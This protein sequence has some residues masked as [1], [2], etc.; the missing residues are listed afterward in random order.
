MIKFTI[1]G[2]PCAKGRARAA[3]RGASIIHYTPEK[4]ANY[5]AIVQLAARQAFAAVK[6][7]PFEGPVTL[8]VFA[9]M[10]IAKSWA[11]KRQE[12]ARNGRDRPTKKPDLSNIV[13]AIEDGMNG[14]AY[15][16]DSQIV[17]SAS[18]KYWSD[19]PRVEIHIEETVL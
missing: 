10:G 9:Y 15:L 17:A 18:F 5:E 14:V 1:P 16:D 8:R 3:I 19:R 6:R 4:T 7:A 13:K 11:K 2:E 12:L